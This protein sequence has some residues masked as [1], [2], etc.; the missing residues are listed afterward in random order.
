M[1]GARIERSLFHAAIFSAILAIGKLLAFLLT[2]SLVVLSSFLDSISDTILSL[3][4][5]R[6]HKAAIARADREHPYGHGGIEIV[7]SLIQ[8]MF[9]AGFG[10]FVVG[11]A[12]LRLYRGSGA[13]EINLEQFG[14]GFLVMLLSGLGS[15][16]IFRYLAETKRKAQAAGEH[17]LVLSADSAHY[18]ADGYV[19]LISAG[20]MLLVWLTDLYWLDMILG[21]VGGFMLF[22][23]A[24]PVLKATFEQILQKELPLNLQQQIVDLAVSAHD[25]VLGVHRL[26]TRSVG[27]TL[28]ADF[29]LRLKGNMSLQA[30]HDI[31]D[32]VAATIR[33]EIPRSDIIIHLDPEDEPKDD[34]WKPA[35]SSPD[36]NKNP[37][38]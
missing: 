5:R 10:F 8:G 36:Q 34:L 29:H 24:W 16:L 21:A 32:H 12:L 17:S 22:K 28:Y 33:K 19:N 26:R 38:N 3:I 31:G 4:N 27:P 11:E 18:S 1:V 23:A 2:G 35:Y 7:A 20:A 13:T 6:L 9:L 15:F 25:N 37:K 14:T 30:A